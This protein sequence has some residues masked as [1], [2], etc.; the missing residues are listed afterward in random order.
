MAATNETL[1]AH[2][3]AGNS[4]D[5]VVQ[6]TGVS[7]ATIARRM[8]DP[9]FRRKVREARAIVLERTLGL[10]AEGSVEAGIV[11]RNLLVNSTSERTKLGAARILLGAEAKFRE[12]EELK[13][14]VEDLKEQ[15]AALQRM[16]K[17]REDHGFTFRN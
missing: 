9:K 1:I 14:D 12:T 15:V 5:A 6:L 17:R 8:R 4:W 3:A 13:A 11:L 16:E 10:I 2:L 7:K